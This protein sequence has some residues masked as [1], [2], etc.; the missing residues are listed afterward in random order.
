MSGSERVYHKKFPR[1][2]FYFRNYFRGANMA[3]EIKYNKATTKNLLLITES[4]VPGTT[5]ATPEVIEVIAQIAAQE[6]SGV[7]SMRGKLSD[8]FASVFGS[9]ARGKGVELQ[10]TIDGLVIEAYVFLQ[11]GVPVPKIALNIQNA[12]KSQVSSMT[13]LEVAR[14]N[15]HVSGIIPEKPD[16]TIDPDNLFGENEVAN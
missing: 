4:E 1:G 6:V 13:D 16:H 15:V 11:Y 7:Y 2:T 10:Q 5:Q 8:R 3:K 12:I 14:V 9:T